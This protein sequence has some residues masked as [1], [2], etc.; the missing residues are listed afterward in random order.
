MFLHIYS[1][2][3]SEELFN[4]RHSSARNIIER[5]FGILKNR[6]GILRVC[7]NV[8]MEVQARLPAALAAI[9][10]FIR[11]YDPGEIQEYL[12]DDEI[13][14]HEGHGLLAQG[15]VTATEKDAANDRRDTI[16]HDMWIQ[17]Q[18]VQNS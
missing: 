13:V 18:E 14:E 8:A 7:P 16:A 17:Y 5:M 6:F 15:A 12:D 2:A 3:N 9:H 11:E 4:L 1:P 10:N